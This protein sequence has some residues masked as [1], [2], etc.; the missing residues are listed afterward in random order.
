VGLENGLYIML[1][2]IGCK[3]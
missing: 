3:D 2:G 1:A